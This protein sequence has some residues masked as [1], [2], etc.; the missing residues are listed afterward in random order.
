MK[1]ITKR[2]EIC[3]TGSADES[4][5]LTADSNSNTPIAI[6]VIRGLD[7]TMRSYF[8]FIGTP[9]TLISYFGPK[10]IKENILVKLLAGPIWNFVDF[11]AIVGAIYGLKAGWKT[12]SFKGEC[13]SNLPIIISCLYMLYRTSVYSTDLENTDDEYHANMSFA[14]AM[15]A[16]I[17]Q[18]LYLILKDLLE[19]GTEMQFLSNHFKLSEQ[20]IYQVIEWGLATAGASGNTAG[21]KIA[22]SVGYA[23][24]ACLKGFG[25]FQS[26]RSWWRGR[27][28]AE[29]KQVELGGMTAS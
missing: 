3:M 18:P 25:V 16:A 22:G 28:E 7:L 12:D 29:D 27:S 11:T 13:I 23:S 10:I 20:A 24:A 4:T 26:V 19:N 1:K 2:W 15:A 9:F 17:V 21:N 5:P 14:F 6:K 8:A